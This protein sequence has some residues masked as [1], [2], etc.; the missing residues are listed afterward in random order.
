MCLRS[1]D[2]TACVYGLGTVLHVFTAMVWCELQRL[3][4]HAVVMNMFRDYSSKDLISSSVL[5]D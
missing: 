1:R 2:R 3:E 4:V 5:K